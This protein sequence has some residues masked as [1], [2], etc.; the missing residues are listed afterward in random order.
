MADFAAALCTLGYC[1][2]VLQEEQ[3]VYEGRKLFFQMTEFTTPD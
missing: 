1:P 2:N 3:L